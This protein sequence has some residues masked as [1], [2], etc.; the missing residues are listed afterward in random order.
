M[1]SLENAIEDHA[2]AVYCSVGLDEG[3]DGWG[4]WNGATLAQTPGMERMCF[5]DHS[6]PGTDE[7]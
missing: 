2:V 3:I 4:S 7:L 5:A 1:V 6:T